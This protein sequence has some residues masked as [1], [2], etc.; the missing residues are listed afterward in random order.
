ME[1]RKGVYFT[2]NYDYARLYAIMKAFEEKQRP[3]VLVC[4]IPND[5]KPIDDE[6]YFDERIPIDAIIEVLRPHMTK[7][8]L[9]D[10]DL[11]PHHL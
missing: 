4:F 7:T 3:V 8:T 10:L 9:R 1:R 5:K 2:P 11:I 6:V